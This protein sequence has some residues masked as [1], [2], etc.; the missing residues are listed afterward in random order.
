MSRRKRKRRIHKPGTAPGTITPDPSAPP[1]LMRVLAFG[2]DTFVERQIEHVDEI[3]AFLPQ[4]RV[5]WLDVNGVGDAATLRRLGEIF[6]LHPLALEDAAHVQQ[7]PKVEAYDQQLFIV[8]R[9]ITLRDELETEQVSIFLGSNFVVTVQEG[10]PGDPFEP[11][12]ERVRRSIGQIRR[13]GPD[14]LA[15]ALLDA[16]IDGYFPVLEEYGERLENIEEC[17]L[18]R[19]DRRLMA[20]LY[21]VKR[22]LL[23]LRRAAWPFRE[24]VNALIRDPNPLVTDDTRLHLRD[25]YDHTVR[26]IDFTETY[27]ELASDLSDVYLSSASHRM[28]EVMKV[29][30][31]I[32]TLFIPLTFI[33]SIYGMNFDPRRSPWNMPEL[34]WY[35]GYPFALGLMAITA[36]A[37]VLYFWWKG[38]L[39]SEA[40]PR[41]QGRLNDQAEHTHDAPGPGCDN[42]KTS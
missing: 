25:C 15:Y 37:L 40:A 30:T 36:I 24:A 9:I 20:D 38:W 28:T 26:I 3:T 33:S 31:I 10:A 14:H 8:A 2:P 32:A 16:V 4:H 29:L 22:G 42:L 5:T 27:R 35:W 6:H 7:R 23:T 13:A 34:E 19:P 17:I 11:V 12:R 39:A 18:A 41:R 1:P 21:G